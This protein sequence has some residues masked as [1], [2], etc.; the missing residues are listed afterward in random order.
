[1]VVTAREKELLAYAIRQVKA[2]GLWK[3][4]AVNGAAK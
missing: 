3:R 4:R 1:V 2:L